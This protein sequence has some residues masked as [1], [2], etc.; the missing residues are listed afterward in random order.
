MRE[1][2][3]LLK[4]QSPSKFVC[5]FFIRSISYCEVKKQL[6]FRIE[7]LFHSSPNRV[8]ILKPFVAAVA[9]TIK[10]EQYAKSYILIN[11]DASPFF[12][13]ARSTY[14]R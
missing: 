14:V 5:L 12:K 7:T 6:L 11:S 8:D 10:Q 2:R 1:V 4:T 9:I 3:R 13:G